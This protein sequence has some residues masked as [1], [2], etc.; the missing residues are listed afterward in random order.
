MCTAS[1]SPA[2]ISIRN[3]D[4]KTA[5]LVDFGCSDEHVQEWNFFEA[6]EAIADASFLCDVPPSTVRVIPS[7][8]FLEDFSLVPRDALAIATL[9]DGLIVFA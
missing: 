4:G 2:R 5:S 8:L 9:K 7:H 6:P 1:A 3:E